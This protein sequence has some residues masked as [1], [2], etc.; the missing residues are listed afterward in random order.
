MAFL[1][2]QRPNQDDEPGTGTQ[3]PQLTM[4]TVV[5]CLLVAAEGTVTTWL[6]SWPRKPGFSL[7]NGRTG[8]LRPCCCAVLSQP[9]PLQHSQ[10]PIWTLGTCVSHNIL[11]RLCRQAGQERMDGWMD[12]NLA[13]TPSLALGVGVMSRSRLYQLKVWIRKRGHLSR[14][15]YCHPHALGPRAVCQ[16]H[17]WY[18]S[19]GGARGPLPPVDMVPW[20]R[21]HRQGNGTLE[22]ALQLGPPLAQ[23]VMASVGGTDSVLSVRAAHRRAGELGPQPS[24]QGVPIPATYPKVDKEGHSPL[25]PPHPPTVAP[26]I[27]SREPARTQKNLGETLSLSQPKRYKRILSLENVPPLWMTSFPA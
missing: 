19:G 14:K 5:C 6:P 26:S 18:T 25:S 16:D 23:P 22:A 27:H 21:A 20:R 24:G 4:Q 3:A 1:P 12:G 17:L 11:G 13:E 8:R 7:V 15:P 2:G 9:Q 10:F